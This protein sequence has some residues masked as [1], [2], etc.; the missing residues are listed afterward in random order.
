VLVG[1]GFAG[2]TSEFAADGTLLTDAHF[3]APTSS[4]RAYRM[5]W[6]GQP[7][8]KPVIAVDA[9][10]TTAKRTLYVSW[11]GATEVR[12]WRVLA[13]A[14]ARDLRAVGAAPRRGFET[15]IA[16]GRASG[17]VAVSALDGTGN[18][19]ATSDTLRL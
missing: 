16:L 13:G 19:L 9:D 7:R 3:L 6:R 4:Y 8:D 17:H 18:V 14:D 11:N 5:R 10:R 1:W 12:R 15:A 2:Y